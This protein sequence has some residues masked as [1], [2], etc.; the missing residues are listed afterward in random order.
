MDFHGMAGSR[1]SRD[2]VNGGGTI[3]DLAITLFW[4]LL[5]FPP[6]QGLFATFY[7]F[8]CV[9]SIPSQRES[10]KGCGI[11]AVLFCMSVVGPSDSASNLMSVPDTRTLCLKVVCNSVCPLVLL[12]LSLLRWSF[13]I[14]RVKW[15]MCLHLQELY[16]LLRAS[17][18]SSSLL[19]SFIQIHRKRI[20][21][22]PFPNSYLWHDL[23]LFQ[24]SCL[25]I[26]KT[27]AVPYRHGA[28]TH[29]S[30]VFRSGVRR[31]ENTNSLRH[32]PTTTT[33]VLLHS[34]VSVR[35]HKNEQ[36]RLESFIASGR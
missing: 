25:I 6:P 4:E 18:C 23:L 2:I 34:T 30:F 26:I 12:L 5:H 21:A 16:L 24:K 32:E 19:I 29:D 11:S 10:D 20:T 31:R 27:A 22:L 9:P 35:R 3:Q 1:R 13:G 7:T 33:T 8:K 36:V 17:S 14:Y 15:K 28:I